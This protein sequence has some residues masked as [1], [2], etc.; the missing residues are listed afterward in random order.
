[1]ENDDILVHENQK[2]DKCFLVSTGKFVCKKN[3]GLCMNEFDLNS[4]PKNS[5][6]LL[7][8]TLKCQVMQI[9]TAESDQILCEDIFFNRESHYNYSVVCQSSNG[10]VLGFS[11]KELL[12]KLPELSV[13]LQEKYA[14][15]IEAKNQKVSQS[16]LN[17]NAL[18]TSNAG[19][20]SEMN[21][22]VERQ[23]PTNSL[24]KNNASKITKIEILN[25]H[26]QKLYK[27]IKEK[28]KHKIKESDLSKYQISNFSERENF[29]IENQQKQRKFPNKYS[30]SVKNILKKSLETTKKDFC[31]KG[32]FV[33]KSNR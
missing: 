4:F 8:N 20:V 26:I 11:K 9:S 1:M 29:L 27:I 3:I 2:A 16:L 7:E 32:F 31:I 28:E 15:Q 25:Q 18:V 30:I 13:L 14:Q 17:L 23:T 12:K 10:A 6:R 33:G 5:Q 21:D 24:M 19:L 22:R